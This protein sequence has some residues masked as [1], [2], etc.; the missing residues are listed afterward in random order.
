MGLGGGGSS[1]QALHFN[2]KKIGQVK[3]SVCYHSINFHTQQTL[4]QR[5]LRQMYMQMHASIHD[6][7]RLLKVLV[8]KEMKQCTKH[9]KLNC[10]RT[11]FGYIMTV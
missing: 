8:H 5:Y 4:V 7:G 1:T 3:T 6:F 10:I 11:C 9:A 2:W